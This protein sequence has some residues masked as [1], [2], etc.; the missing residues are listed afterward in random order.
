MDLVPDFDPEGEW[1]VPTVETTDDFELSR[2]VKERGR[3]T[4]EYDLLSN[5][6]TVKQSLMNWETLFIR[7]RDDNGNLLP[8]KVALPSIADVEEE[9]PAPAPAPSKGKRKAGPED[10]SD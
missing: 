8:V 2:A 7:F 3:P 10:F 9:E 4:G 6:D 5:K 1:A